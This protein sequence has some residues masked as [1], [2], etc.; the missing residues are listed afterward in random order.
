MAK[1]P[2][3]DGPQ[4]EQRG[5]GAPTVGGQGPDNSGLMQ[6][7]NQLGNSVVALVAKSRE[8][9]ESAQAKEAALIY[10]RFEQDLKYNPETGLYN[11]RG[12]GAQDITNQGFSALDK[13]FS[14]IIAS[15]KNERVR[16]RFTEY[17][18]GRRESF[19]REFN[20]YEFEQNEVY[21]DQVD[22][23]LLETAMQGAALA[24]KDAGKVSEYQAMVQGLVRSKAQRKGLPDEQ[25][26]MQVLKTNSALVSNVIQRLAIENPQQ[27]KQYFESQAGGM[28]ADDQ[29]QVSRAIERQI[30]DR[31]IEARQM[32]AIRRTE[33]S[34]RVA[35]ATAAYMAGYEF[36][37]PLAESEFVAAYGAEEG[38][39]RYQ[40]FQ[41]VPALGSAIRE[42][43]TASPE[44]RAAILQRFDPARGGVA[45]EGFQAD[46]KAY[47]ALVSAA[48]RFAK[49]MESDPAA[50]VARRSEIVRKSA[51]GLTSGDPA[52][53]AA[54]VTATVAEQQRVGIQ[55]P[56]L[57]TEW[58][59]AAIASRFTE[60]EDG[61]NKSADLIEG[62]RHQWGNSWPAVYEQLQGKLPPAALVI[63]SGVDPKT[64]ATLSRIASLKTEELK[65]GLDST[66]IRDAKDALNSKLADFRV[67][68]NGQVGGER[69]FNTLHSELERLT[70][71]YMGQGHS[72]KDAAEQA[73]DAVVGAKYT[74]EDTYRVPSTL[75][76]GLV[77]IGAQA[78]LRK[79]DTSD[80]DNS[81][82]KWADDE[83]IADRLK[84]VPHQGYWVTLP[85]ES[86]LALY[87]DGEAV[88][89]KAQEPITRSFESLIELATERLG[90]IEEAFPDG[91]M[92]DY[93]KTRAAR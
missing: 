50:Y 59:A 87:L 54:Y 19:G 44:E 8:E 84:E 57:L 86:G 23:G 49:E 31:E 82:Y 53:T 51:E 68:L 74:I 89:N 1:I 2:T 78:A 42:L 25:T 35:D 9:A 64:A 40:E 5:I 43:S 17:R 69:T 67:T 45:G 47:S 16:R 10:D 22:D 29:V 3:I 38:R 13:K 21:K 20:R 46:A 90:S 18:N 52:A 92:L 85:D 61:G 63:A 4:V 79:L 28:T 62:L 56:K 36:K 11:R 37:K 6:G 65:K 41:K 70:Y 77:K 60:V 27:A 39:A 58:Q 72:S 24:Y 66:S 30:K 91:R 88:L 81:T 12:K 71:A 7:F 32:Q 26:Q 80:I 48:S 55:K 75:D 33:L 73:Y 83:F 76:A 34:S 93:S 14:E 15:I